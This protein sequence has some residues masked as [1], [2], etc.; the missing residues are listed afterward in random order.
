MF[1]VYSWLTI[2][3]AKKTFT[4]LKKW[5]KDNPNRTDCLA[6]RGLIKRNNI[7]ADFRRYYYNG[8]GSLEKKKSVVVVKKKT[9]K[10]KLVK[11]PSK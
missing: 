4:K 2:S 7:E 1:I 3:G 6:D 10:K 5:F 8:N 9:S 11:K